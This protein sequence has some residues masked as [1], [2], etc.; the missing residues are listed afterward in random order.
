MIRSFAERG[1]VPVP[2][3]RF[4]GLALIGLMLKL[5]QD[6]CTM[7]R[8]L[9][10]NRIN[11][12]GLMRVRRDL[13]RKLQA[14]NLGYHH[15]RPLGD[16]IYRL[17]SD[18]FGFQANL[19]VLISTAVAVVT[20]I[21]MVLILASRNGTVTLLALSVAPFLMAANIRFGRTLKARS[22]EA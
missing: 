10:N 1:R 17:S 6:L 5:L 3:S 2:V 8:T 4:S 22:A 16:A 18:T 21:A 13:Y 14:L 9:V 20:R 19:S 7:V 12:N 11:Y 15:S